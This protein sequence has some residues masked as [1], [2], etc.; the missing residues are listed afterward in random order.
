[1]SEDMELKWEWPAARKAEKTIVI[2]VTTLKPVGSGLFGLKKTPSFA[3]NI[4][5]PITISG[6]IQEQDSPLD[7]KTLKITAPKLE[8]GSLKTGEYA[9]LGIINNDVCICIVSGK[10]TQEQGNILN[11]Q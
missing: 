3:A 11:C 10:E 8:L 6:I 4:P 7:G 5:D 2:E 1:M 9:T